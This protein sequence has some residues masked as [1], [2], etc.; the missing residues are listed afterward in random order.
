MILAAE[1]G[2]QLVAADVVDVACAHPGGSGLVVPITL[3]ARREITRSATMFDGHSRQ[4]SRAV[5]Y[6]LRS[7]PHPSQGAA[8]AVLGAWGTAQT[9]VD[10]SGGVISSP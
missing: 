3:R 1:S 2:R 6:R 7:V 4:P 10:S 8:M 9:S 5:T